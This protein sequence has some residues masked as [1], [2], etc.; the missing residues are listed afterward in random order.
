[1][2]ASSGLIRSHQVQSMCRNNLTI[3]L[4]KFLDLQKIYMDI[5]INIFIRYTHKHE[6]FISKNSNIDIKY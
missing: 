6:N 4:H 3:N 2:I 5:D 1:M